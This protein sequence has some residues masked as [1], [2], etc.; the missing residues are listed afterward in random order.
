M[1]YWYHLE[2][3]DLL[4]P[5][6]HRQA[7]EIV[8]SYFGATANEFAFHFWN[9]SELDQ[10]PQLK[11]NVQTKRL[12]PDFAEGSSVAIG[13]LTP[14]LVEIIQALP[15]EEGHTSPWF[16]SAFLLNHRPILILGDNGGDIT[17]FC[18]ETE[19][20]RLH[21]LFTQAGLP[22]VVDQ[23]TQMPDDVDKIYLGK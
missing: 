13:W 4:D 6:A 12:T 18:S 21:T 7:W 3:P 19:L 11:Q 14:Q 15:R 10:F 23:I 20:D 2:E 17:F 1:S 5:A 9:E 22:F 16:D 8:T